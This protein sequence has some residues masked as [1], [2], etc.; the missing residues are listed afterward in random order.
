MEKHFVWV[1]T[2]LQANEHHQP[3]AAEGKELG[4]SIFF[5]EGFLKAHIVSRDVPPSQGTSGPQ[6][7]FPSRCLP[8]SGVLGKPGVQEHPS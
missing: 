3:G 7:H 8:S 6:G 2:V 5:L 4:Q 1:I